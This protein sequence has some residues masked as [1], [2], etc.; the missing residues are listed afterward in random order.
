MMSEAQGTISPFSHPA[1]PALFL[2]GEQVQEF[3]VQVAVGFNSPISLP[4][5][6]L[7]RP[8]EICTL[9]SQMKQKRCEWVYF[10]KCPAVSSRNL[11]QPAV[12]STLLDEATGATVQNSSREQGRAAGLWLGE[13]PSGPLLTGLP[14]C[15]C[16]DISEQALIHLNL[17]AVS[18]HP[19]IP[20]VLGKEFGLKKNEISG[21]APGKAVMSPI[22]CHS[23]H[24]LVRMDGGWEASCHFLEPQ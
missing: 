14:I 9:I 19:P 18:M 3:L 17:C 7:R 5:P 6:A 8:Q 12:L 2:R 24:W 10:P 21:Q 16:T 13:L 23:L 22:P 15:V 11:G 4:A 20:K 1:A